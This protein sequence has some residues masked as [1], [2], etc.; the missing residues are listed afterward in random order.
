MTGDACSRSPRPESAGHERWSPRDRGAGRHSRV[1]ATFFRR[2]AV[3]ATALFILAGFG[4][5][6]LV[7]LVT[8][9]LGLVGWT[10]FATA[11]V[12]VLAAALVLANVFGAMRRFASPLSALMDAADRVA[13]GDYT[14][15][16]HEYGPPPMR[17]L[18]RSFN[19]MTGRLENADRQ[20]RNLM[21]DVAHELRTPLS[22]LQG[23]LEGLI[24]GVYRCDEGQLE[25]LLEETHVLS[26]LV[27][28]LRTLALS[29][30]G[31]MALHKEPTD[32][33]GLVRDILGSFEADAAARAVTLSVVEPGVPVVADV[34]AV[35]IREVCSNLLSNALRHTPAGGRVTALVSGAGDQASIEV[36]D[37]GEGMAP[38]DLARMFDRFYK[39]AASRGS[40]LGLAIA[41]NLV[42]AHGGTI[43]AS[44]Q[45]GVGTTVTVTLGVRQP[46][47]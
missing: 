13:G 1:R 2:F 23:R 28:D 20:R 21:A 15:R 43:A 6:A 8:A 47:F 42:E 22:V 39:G 10:A 24:D 17:A 9:R 16:V 38:E 33:I 25:Q 26:R 11:V 44:S 5:V 19:T 4:I 36:R 37:T 27:E 14:V 46:G 29:E 45:A 18:T 3:V 31:M 41:K 40:G 34:D 30:A 12:A 35:R 32:L 7:S